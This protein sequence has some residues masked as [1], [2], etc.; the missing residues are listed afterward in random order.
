MKMS[1][2]VRKEREEEADKHVDSKAIVELRYHD[3]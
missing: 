1:E 2:I 3:R